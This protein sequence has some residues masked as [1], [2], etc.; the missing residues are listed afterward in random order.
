MFLLVKY[1]RFELNQRYTAIIGK[2]ILGPFAS[3][4]SLFYGWISSTMDC[5]MYK[6]LAIITLDA[7]ETMQIVYVLK[8][9]IKYDD[10]SQ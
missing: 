4:I 5:L 8:T 9:G 7:Q 2:S 6:L 10:D 3:V 1:R